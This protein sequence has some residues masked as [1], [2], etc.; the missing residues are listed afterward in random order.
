VESDPPDVWKKYGIATVVVVCCVV[1]LLELI[2]NAVVEWALMSRTGFDK[3]GIM[4]K[5]SDLVHDPRTFRF[6]AYGAIATAPE[7]NDDNLLF[8][9]FLVDVVVVGGV[10]TP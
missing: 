9:V 8:C 5:A 7:R 10:S 3:D 6:C 4:E 1:M 2:A